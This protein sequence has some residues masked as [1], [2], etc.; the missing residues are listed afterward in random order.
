VNRE[1]LGLVDTV[2]FVE[3]FSEDGENEFK[4]TFSC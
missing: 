2:K 4:P 3:T 1:Y